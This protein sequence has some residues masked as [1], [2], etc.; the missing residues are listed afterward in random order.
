M[1]YNDIPFNCISDLKINDCEDA[2]N[3]NDT[4][5]W[6]KKAIWWLESQCAT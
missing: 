4:E 6:Q 2:A 5:R 3:L 1:F